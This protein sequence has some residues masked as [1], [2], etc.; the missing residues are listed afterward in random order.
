M[1][2][3]SS[4]FPHKRNGGAERDRTADPLLAKQVLSQL[5]YSPN[6]LAFTREALHGGAKRLATALGPA[7]AKRLSNQHNTQTLKTVNDPQ[8]NPYPTQQVQSTTPV[9][10]RAVRSAAAKGR[11]SVRTE[12]WWARVDSNYRPHA[13]QACALTD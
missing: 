13:Y 9:V 10:R 2:T 7:K 6:S 11:D 1:R 8:V 12:Q 3:K 4:P 5:S